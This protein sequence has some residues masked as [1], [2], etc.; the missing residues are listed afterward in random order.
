MSTPVS[1]I[2]PQALGL[3]TE[4]KLT[5]AIELL[6]SI[7]G[8]GPIKVKGA[9]KP[10]DPDAPK[11]VVGADSYIHLVNKVVWPVLQRLAEG[12]SDDEKLVTRSVSARTQVAKALWAPIQALSSEERIEKMTSLTEAQILAAYRTW[13]AEPREAKP[14]K[15]ED[16]ASAASGGS[17]ASSKGKLSTMSEEEKKAF[18]KARGEASAAARAAKK[19]ANPEAAS[20]KPKKS[21]KTTTTPV[22]APVAPAAPAPA[23]EE[24]F[25]EEQKTWVH[26]GKAYLRVYNY[27]WDAKSGNWVGEWDPATKKIDTNAAEPETE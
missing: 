5:L 21:K 9:R 4:E 12:Q 15:S 23:T 10:R 1:I 13:A 20:E 16:G 27:L 24:E 22:A 25:G 8:S 17:K 18:Y 11:R 7:N 3:S 19:A 26:E 14:K 6:S 2:T